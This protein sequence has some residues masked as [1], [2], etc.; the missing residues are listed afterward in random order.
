MRKQAVLGLPHFILLPCPP[1]QEAG[2]EAHALVAAAAELALASPATAGAGQ[3][4][5]QA[6][7][8]VAGA[9][10]GCRQL[11]GGG[12]EEGCHA[13]LSPEA[14]AARQLA[15]LRALQ[16]VVAAAQAM[17]TELGAPGA[18]LA[19]RATNVGA[20]VA[21][22]L[23]ALG[24][25]DAAVAGKFEW[26]DGALTRWVEPF[27]RM[28]VGWWAVHKRSHKGTRHPSYVACSV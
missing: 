7:Q 22:L 9:W 25:G 23:E 12:G 15:A 1:L 2:R 28:W 10:D 3:Q 4:A 19:T 11:L 21:A 16:Q 17:A 14:Q 26:V 6:L 5:Q 8:A 20:R 18:G 13:A 27:V 24:A